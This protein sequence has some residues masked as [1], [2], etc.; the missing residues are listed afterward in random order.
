MPPSSD[1]LTVTALRRHAGA[2]GRFYVRG[3][4][5]AVLVIVSGAAACRPASPPAAS[6]PP[7]A[8]VTLDVTFNRDIAPLLFEH[9]AT[10]HRPGTA[11]PFSVLEYEP[12]RQNADEILGATSS[13]VMPPWPPEHGYGEFL[14]ARRALTDEEV[15]LIA[16]WVEAGRPEG[17][18]ADRPPAP[19][20]PEGWQLGKPDL[21][22]QSPESFT[23]PATG[24]DIFRY[25]VI[26][27]PLA[28][29]RYVRAVEF[30]PSN[31]KVIH[32]ASLGVDRMR[33]SRRPDRADPGPGFAA[34]PDDRVQNVY[35][36]TNGKLPF[37]EPAERAWRLDKGSDLVLQLHML[38]SGQPEVVQ[39]AVGLFFSDVPP[40]H[41]PL[42]VTL[43]SRAIEIPAGE[44]DYVIEDTYVLPADVDV[45]SVYPHAHYLGN[46]LRG[47][48]TLPDGSVTWLVWIKSWN[49]R[50]QDQYRYVTPLFLPKGTT[51]TMR[52]SYDNSAANPRNPTRPPV[53]VTWGPQSTDE[54]GA[55][56][57]EILPRRAAD[58]ATLLADFAQRSLRADLAGARMQV[59]RAPED[60]LA[61]NYLATRY[62]QAGLVAEAV[63]EIEAALGLRPGDAE[64][65]SNLGSIRLQQGRLGE[66]L[67]H[68]REAAR[69]G[70]EDDRIRV[71]LGNVLNA[72]GRVDEAMQE[73]REAIRINPDS[74]DAHFNLAV[75]LG[76]G[77]ELGEAEQHLRRAIDVN[78]QNADAHRNLGLALAL[79][80]RVEAAIDEM[81][82]ALRIQPGFAA[83]QRELAGLEAARVRAR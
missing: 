79:Q 81:R 66:A 39:P 68:L 33:V 14:N 60:P 78:P 10:C 83:A 6:D 74:A 43:E 24:G 70:P 55:L 52:Y 51:L 45:L 82:E 63:A 22:V 11:A 47:Y 30:R 9:C 17:D 36:W 64:A 20:F 67:E 37:L 12:V 59:A 3:V 18:S 35:G 26:P 23:V 32:H 27:V 40:T 73:Y 57:L 77:N 29:T 80:G 28:A 50:W 61:H 1:R 38:P 8:G 54:M 21:V 53:R 76:A 16:R 72:A 15:N 31:P 46:D 2:G 5:L 41:V 56:W 71:N 34:M 58:A 44:P 48:A 65:R 42:L 13:G 4:R 19:I 25:F 7:P 49:F 75:L 69:V 62:L